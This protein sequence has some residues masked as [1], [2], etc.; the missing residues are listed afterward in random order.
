MDLKS[1]LFRD[2]M[3]S[4]WLA[5]YVLVVGLRWDLGWW[6]VWWMAGGLAA[7]GFVLIDRLVG[8]YLL[9]SEVPVAVELRDL[10]NRD[11]WREAINFLIV[12]GGEQR[13]LMG[14]SVVFL[15]V[16][17]P[18]A[19]FLLTSSPSW[20]ARGLVMGIGLRA[21]IQMILYWRRYDLLSTT[22]FWQIKREVPENEVRIVLGVII[23]LFCGLTLMV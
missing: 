13:V 9:R 17:I 21:V 10:V 14:Y 12:R 23:G 1:Y 8:M 20:F 2:R 22:F 18:L 6:I 19:F 15:V 11:R 16:W 4:M 7:L 5:F 3:W